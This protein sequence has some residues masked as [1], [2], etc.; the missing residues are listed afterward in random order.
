[1]TLGG[2]HLVFMGYKSWL[3]PSGWSGNG[4]L[5]PI[6]LVAITFFVTGYI[7]NLFGRK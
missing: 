6:S 4:G 7:I 1:M 2:V 3:N 5:P